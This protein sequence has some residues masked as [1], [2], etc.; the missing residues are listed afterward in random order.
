MNT[1]VLILALS[2]LPF[3]EAQNQAANYIIE[4][5]AEGAEARP[6]KP[7]MTGYTTCP[8]CNGRKELLLEEPDFGQNEGRLG[9]ARKTK[10]KCPLCRGEG[11]FASFMDPSDIVLQIA[12]DHDAFVAEHR[13]K[14]EISVGEAF[15]PNAAYDTLDKNRKKLIEEAFGKP[16]TKCNW[17]GIEACRKCSGKGV[18]PCPE[19]DCRN[20]FLVTKTTTEKTRRSSGGTSNGGYNRNSGYR[21]SSGSRSKTIK[22]TKTTVLLCPTCNGGK[23][24]LCPDCNG[25][26]A[27]PCKKCNGTGTKKKGGGL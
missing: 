2:F 13:G 18:Q 24:I 11:R 5:P 3:F 15:V 20:G 16:C 1:P 17:S 12:R 10:R 26:K 23:F 27:H 6:E 22:E 7:D 19:H 8:S 4:P 9:G 25:R 14:G 21:S